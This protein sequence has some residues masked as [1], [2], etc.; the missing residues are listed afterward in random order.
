MSYLTQI[1]GG[2][3]QDASGAPIAKGTLILKLDADSA[4]V[5]PLS[6][7]GAA[8]VITVTLD[9]TG[10]VATSPAVMVAA[11]DK[12]NPAGSY[13]RATVYSA[14][15]QT[16]WG[17][18]NVQ[19][20]YNGGIFNLNTLVPFSAGGTSGGIGNL[21]SDD[22][23]ISIV[24]N[25]AGATD[26]TVAN[27]ANVKHFGNAL[28]G[29]GKQNYAGAMASLS[30]VVNLRLGTQSNPNA[31]ISGGQ[32][33]TT[34]DVGKSILVSGP[35][36]GAGANALFDLWTTITA[37][38]SPTQ[39]V[40]ADAA[41]SGGI[42]TNFSG[43]VFWFDAAS[44]DTAAIQAAIN[45]CDGSNQYAKV[46]LPA[47]VYIRTG[48]LTNSLNMKEFYGDGIKRTVILTK[49][50]LIDTDALY[51]TDQVYFKMK[52]MTWRGPGQDAAFG[53][54]LRFDLF[55]ESVLFGLSFEDVEIKHVAFDGI[56]LNTPILTTFR[57][58]LFNF[59]AGN[60][61]TL[62]TAVATTFDSCYFITNLL[63]G[64]NMQNCAA[65]TFNSCAAESN[66]IGYYANSGTWSVAFNGCDSEFQTKRTASAPASFPAVTV[67]TGGS[68]G[69]GTYRFKY[70]WLRRVTSNA[71]PL[72]SLPSPESAPVSVTSGHQTVSFTLPAAPTDVPFINFANVYVT[73]SATGTET[74]LG[75]VGLNPSAPTTM[76]YSTPIA[77]DGV[78]HPPLT[79][80]IGHH[81]AI[82]NAQNITFNSC[83]MNTVP[84]LSNDPR[85]IFIS[86]TSSQISAKQLRLIQQLSPNPAF[87]VELDAAP[88]Y[89]GSASSQI[90]IESGDITPANVSIGSGVSGV[91][92]NLSGAFSVPNLTISNGNA[93]ATSSSAGITG[94]LAYDSSFLYLATGT[95]TWKRVALSSF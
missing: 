59:T 10:N 1:I 51:F 46:Y 3:F 45:A 92:L 49:S 87:W 77:G 4:T 44:D 82:E 84:V 94:T 73:N 5:P 12:L 48:T 66:G 38:T 72:E 8:R 53:G 7:I 2:S 24:L 86:G 33:F 29:A 41:P 68:V 11:N 40:L 57:N 80:M 75:M 79:S 42:A 81:A 28:T 78:T 21:V 25:Q 47:G 20:L 85:F 23:S 89:G 70:T 17:P 50:A 15:G 18:N 90:W 71:T 63:A 56:Y 37:V 14:Q 36:G 43:E 95:N 34:D 55:V 91:T 16:I 27:V 83:T 76:T 6:E 67:S 22:G 64:V 65:L 35:N 61:I 74:F 30:N 58:C 31:P 39:A 62:N 54:R 69:L 93:P 19:I 13:Y 52:G 88:P 9:A 26:I 60:G 32:L